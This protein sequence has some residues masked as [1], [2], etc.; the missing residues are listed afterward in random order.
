MTRRSRNWKVYSECREHEKEEVIMAVG[1]EVRRRGAP[2]WV[3]SS[4]RGRLPASRFDSRL[5]ERF[6]DNLPGECFRQETEVSK[7]LLEGLRTRPRRKVH[8]RAIRPVAIAVKIS[9]GS[10]TSSSVPE[11]DKLASFV[12]SMKLRDLN[13]LTVGIRNVAY[14]TR[15]LVP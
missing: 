8:S 4:G 1:A 12:H 15:G 11:F 9:G 7:R 5:L 10:H 3:R 6:P 14:I 13:F 2:Y